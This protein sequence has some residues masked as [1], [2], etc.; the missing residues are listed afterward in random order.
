MAAAAALYAVQA[1]LA[2]RAFHPRRYKDIAWT[3][4]TTK[5]MPT[6]AAHTSHVQ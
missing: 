3:G 6:T 4:M 2:A 1:E 5:L